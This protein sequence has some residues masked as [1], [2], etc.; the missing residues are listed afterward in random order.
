MKIKSYGK[1]KSF[2]GSATRITTHSS[3][4]LFENNGFY[5]DPLQFYRLTGFSWVVLTA[6]GAAV[7]WRSYWAGSLRFPH[8]HWYL[9]LAVGTGALLGQG[10][11]PPHVP[12]ATAYG[13]VAEFWEGGV[14][15]VEDLVLSLKHPQTTFC[16]AGLPEKRGGTAPCHSLPCSASSNHNILL[17]MLQHAFEQGVSS[18]WNAVPS[19]LRQVFPTHTT[20]WVI[21]HF[22]DSSPNNYHFK[23]SK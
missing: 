2:V 21:P 14:I 10:M 7:I 1:W 12:W 17:S 8:T 22:S 23:G 16:Q 9:I 6:W 15:I 18:T 5:D 20:S 4:Q 13:M 3:Y 11:W 19:S